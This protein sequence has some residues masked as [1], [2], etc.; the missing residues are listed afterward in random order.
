MTAQ[1]QVH[2]PNLHE[3]FCAKSVGGRGH[4]G[5]GEGSS[6]SEGGSGPRGGWGGWGGV[7]GGDGGEGDSAGGEA[8]CEHT[9]I[10]STLPPELPIELIRMRLS[11]SVSVTKTDDVHVQVNQLPVPGKPT[12]WS[13]LPFTMSCKSR[14]Q[15]LCAPEPFPNPYRQLRVTVVVEGAGT[16]H[17]RYSHP[18]RKPAFA[19]QSVNATCAWKLMYPVPRKPDVSLFKRG[20]TLEVTLSAS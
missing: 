16:V 1:S 6:G 13:A 9:R 5:G 12:T 14:L 20:P 7:H 11:P 4:S 15:S 10:S 17:S 19:R 3:E 2:V 8:C 18:M